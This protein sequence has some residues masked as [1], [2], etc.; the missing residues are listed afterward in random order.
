MGRNE[1]NYRIRDVARIVSEVVPDSVVTYAEGGGPDQR[2]YRVDCSKI[3][4]A[5]RISSRSGQSGR[6]SSSFTTPSAAIG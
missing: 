1:E 3:A 5:S 6:G 4:R 2:C